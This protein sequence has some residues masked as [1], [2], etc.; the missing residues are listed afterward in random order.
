MN[1]LISREEARELM[2]HNQEPLTEYDLDSLPSIEAEPVRHGY[3]DVIAVGTNFNTDR[4]CS[5]CK[6]EI[7]SNYWNYCPNCGAKIDL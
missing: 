2:Y 5:H 1:D 3:W 6:K 4:L 7:K